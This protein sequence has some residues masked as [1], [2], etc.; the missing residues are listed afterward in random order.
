M[1]YGTIWPSYVQK[2][3]ILQKF[4]LVFEAC[5]GRKMT[6]QK[7]KPSGILHFCI[8]FFHISRQR[9]N[10]I[11][12]RSGSEIGRPK[13]PWGPHFM[14]LQRPHFSLVNLFVASTLLAPCWSPLG[15]L[16][17]TFRNPLAALLETLLGASWGPLRVSLKLHR[18]LTTEF[19]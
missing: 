18:V 1:F 5:R 17:G 9:I 10:L 8:D 13:A 19:H 15:T 4:C 11:N 12:G 2:C 7:A 3:N 6:F 16:L 14:L